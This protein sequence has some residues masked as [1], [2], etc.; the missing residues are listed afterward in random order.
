MKNKKY[1]TVRIIPKSNL[2]AIETEVKSIPLAYDSL[3]S[4]RGTG[5]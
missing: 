4:W 1:H 2:K 3:Q 5:T